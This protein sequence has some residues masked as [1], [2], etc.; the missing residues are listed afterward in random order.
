M[1][2][3]GINIDYSTICTD[4]NTAYL[5]RDN[6]DP[7]TTACMRAVV[8][9]IS[10]FLHALCEQFGYRLYPLNS[11]RAVKVAYVASNRFLFY[12]LEKEIT[13]QRFV[14]T[15]SNTPCSND[16]EWIQK[17][18]EGVMICNDEEG[19]G[20]YLYLE[21]ESPLYAWVTGQLSDLS[22]DEVPVP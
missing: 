19:E 5:D 21:K 8:S 6:N 7:Q 16:S 18:E 2:L 13:L 14:A 9:R 1:A 3:T 4:Y 12:S 22:W 10:E 15:Q 11:D 17:G 20:I